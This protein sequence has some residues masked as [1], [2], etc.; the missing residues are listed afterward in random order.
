MHLEEKDIKNLETFIDNYEF[1]SGKDDLYTFS[2]IEKFD[3]L[4]NS[5]IFDLLCDK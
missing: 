3:N 2:H 1:I 4:N 5:Y